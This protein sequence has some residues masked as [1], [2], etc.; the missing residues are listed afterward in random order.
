MKTEI[1]NILD[2]PII[3]VVRNVKESQALYIIEAL[4]NGGINNI[5]M[6]FGKTSPVNIIRDAKK[7]FGED[8]HVGAGTVVTTDQVKDAVNAGAQ[9]IFSP[10]FKVEVVEETLRNDIISIPGCFSPS[11]I[12]NAY[13]LGAQIVKVF[14]ANTL[15]AGF[16]KN[17]KAPLPYLNIVP[18][19]G[20]NK[21]NMTEFLNAGAIA[22]GLGSSLL[23]KHL[24]DE[25]KYKELT[26]H[27]KEL[28]SIAKSAQ[29]KK[30]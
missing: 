23:D 1:K 3:A 30:F 6:T 12:Y 8:I 11:E 4:L 9:F 7:R 22:V 26:D 25:E 29:V 24:I 19:G 18:T 17:I 15:G 14:P 2:S 13:S 20:I 21:D 27:A 16:I 10:N 5:E 28:I